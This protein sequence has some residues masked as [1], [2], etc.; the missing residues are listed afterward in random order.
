MGGELGNVITPQGVK[1][2]FML[3]ILIHL[4]FMLVGSYQKCA[5][6]TS[7][8]KD[9]IIFMSQ[10]KLEDDVNNIGIGEILTQVM[11]FLLRNEPLEDTADNLI[12]K[13]GKIVLMQNA[14]QF[15][16]FLDYPLLLREGNSINKV[17]SVDCL[18][19]YFKNLIEII[20]EVSL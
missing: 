2:L 12:A 8:V 3:Q 7:R 10:T 20:L 1:K 14:Y 18:I 19:V 6:T 4:L 13:L 9:F 15:L 11:P 16:Y 17:S 5:S